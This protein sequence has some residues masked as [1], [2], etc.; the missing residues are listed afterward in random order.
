M[1]EALIRDQ[2]NAG[3]VECLL[4]T[5]IALI[6]D[7]DHDSLKKIKNFEAFF[8]RCKLFTLQTLSEMHNFGTVLATN[9]KFR[10][11][12]VFCYSF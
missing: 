1:L 4:D 3:N 6:S 12:I 9:Y 5:L 10:P 2:S 7:C 11:Q 8:N